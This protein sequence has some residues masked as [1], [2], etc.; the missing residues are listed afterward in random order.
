[1]G[2]GADSR[3][4]AFLKSFGPGL[5]WAGTAIGVSHLVQS[6]RA[7]A[8][9]GLGL[10]GVI[11]F[12]L[13]LKY[14]FFAFGPLYA[15]ATGES[16]VEGYL[17][18]GRWA[19][20][21]YFAVVLSTVVFTHAAIVLFT[22]YLLLF[23]FGS[24]ASIPLVAVLI[25]GACISL[26]WVGR[27]RAL[28]VTIKIVLSVLVVSTLVAAL[29]VL[30]G[31]SVGTLSLLPFAP[32][33][34]AVPFAFV[35]ALAGWMPSDIAISGMSSLWT[36]AKSEGAG[37]RAHVSA[38]RLDFQLAYA[39][40]GVLAFAFLI[41]GAG[42]MYQ[43]GETF[44][45]SGAVFSTQLIDVY[46]ATLGAWSRPVIMLTA[47]TAMGSTMLAIVDGYPR[48]IDRLT[49]A[50]TSGDPAASAASRLS[51]PYWAS[52]VGVAALTVLFLWLFVGSLT[53][54][55]DFVTTVAFLTGPVLGY[56]NLRVM[57]SPQ[58]PVEHRP[59]PAMRVFAYSGL[60]VLALV[61]LAFL[62]NLVS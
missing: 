16:L 21:L 28:D 2:P 26:L 60:I 62:A 13:V 41:L 17:R 48:V 40:T 19:V 23:A 27:F 56:L 4:R 30:P 5:L 39:A 49:K 22:A 36:V 61:A 34:S 3:W 55:V 11:L 8:D 45:A 54:M 15:A 37:T 6:T 46:A 14:P 9:A 38:V 29:M 10:A 59:G 47:I 25:Y 18:I 58:V 7:G 12:A 20:W 33:A 53:Q 35:L 51:G 31:V 32:V 52:M 43:S 44:S 57:T 1:M 50:V 42:V 24:T